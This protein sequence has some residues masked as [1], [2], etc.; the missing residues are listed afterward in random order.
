MSFR[1]SK[2][3]VHPDEKAIRI[4]HENA[5]NSIYKYERKT[6]AIAKMGYYRASNFDCDLLGKQR[7]ESDY[8]V[9]SGVLDE[10]FGSKRIHCEVTFVDRRPEDGFVGDCM[11]THLVDDA[12]SHERA[13]MLSVSIWDAD[14]HWRRAAYDCLRD[15][16]ISNNQF[17]HFRIATELADVSEVLA[18]LSERG[19]GPTLR[20]HEF[21]MWPTIILPKAPDWAWKSS[22]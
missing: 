5:V 12:E 17:C 21:T 8:F 16:A 2:R 3:R 4:A 10:T 15:A 20:L 14:S 6:L 1:K 9:M 13:L 7:P 11:L 19:Y 18:Q 22:V